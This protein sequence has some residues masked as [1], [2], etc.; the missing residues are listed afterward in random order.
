MRK[1]NILMAKEGEIENHDGRRGIDL[2]F[3]LVF[4]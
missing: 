4:W 2:L 1:A 3:I